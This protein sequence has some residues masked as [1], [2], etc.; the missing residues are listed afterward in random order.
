MPAQTESIEVDVATASELRRRATERGVSVA[1]LIAE[2][3]P[4]AVDGES[5]AE[6]KRQWDLIERGEIATVP[7]SEVE[8]WL[9]TWGT[10]EFRP[11]PEQ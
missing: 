8:H 7:H 11:W 3:V 9:R 4:L 2:L 1:A 6:L 5:L 10:P